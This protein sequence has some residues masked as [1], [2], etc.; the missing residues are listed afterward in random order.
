MHDAR[1]TF[2]TVS[3][4]SALTSIVPERKEHQMI[5]I[6]NRK[7]LGV[8]TAVSGCCHDDHT[9]FDGLLDG[10]AQHL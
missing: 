5:M 2:Q 8:V 10:G 3:K 9:V 4:Q 6:G 7:V 1:G